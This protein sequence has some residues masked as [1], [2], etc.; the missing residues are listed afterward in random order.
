[1]LID[2]YIACFSISA[3]FYSNGSQF[4]DEALLQ[5]NSGFKIEGTESETELSSI[6]QVSQRFTLKP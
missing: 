6:C 2:C 1:M 5:C 3:T 4:Q